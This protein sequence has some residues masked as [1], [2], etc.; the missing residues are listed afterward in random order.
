MHFLLIILVSAASCGA[1]SWFV[2]RFALKHGLYA[3]PRSR[4]VHSKPTP[5]LGGVAM[6]SGIV[7]ATG[8]AIALPV[9]D[10]LF[11]DKKRFLA[12]AAAVLLIAVVGV[13]DDLFDLDWMIKLGAQ[14]AAAG[15][16][17]WQGVQVLSVPFGDTLVLVSPAMNMVLTVFLIVLVMNAINFVDGMDGLVVGVALIASAVF[18]IYTLLLA[19]ETGNSGAIMLASLLAAMTVGVCIGFLPYN[20]HRAKMFMGDTGALLI[21]LLM[22]VSTISVTGQLNPGA[23]NQ[24][25]VLASYIPIIL[26]VAVLAMPLADFSLAVLRRIRAGQSPFAAD[27]KHLH[28]RLLDYGHSPV[29]VV[30]IFYL[31]TLTISLACLLVFTTQSYVVPL[32]VMVAGGLL[33]LLVTIV[34]F[35][36]FKDA[37]VRRGLL[38]LNTKTKHRSEQQ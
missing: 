4:D 34:P 8:F 14:L 11:V 22:A 1:V 38:V 37:L 33:C 18:L 24:K 9:F 15:L 12:M 6:F 29:Q 13:L 20:W 26:P 21:G 7:A 36:V 5:R 30:A 25:L 17:A 31:W 3:E 16:L 19:M 23:L 32:I 2:L 10:P 27:R 35:A 28:H